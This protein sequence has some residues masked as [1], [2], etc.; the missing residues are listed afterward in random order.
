M[1]DVANLDAHSKGEQHAT[2]CSITR[3][4]SICRALGVVRV[5]VN[6]DGE[7]GREKLMFGGV[8]LSGLLVTLTET[9]DSSIET[10]DAGDDGWQASLSAGSAER[11][12]EKKNPRYC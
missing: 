4:G 8:E 1:G 9:A 3:C 6:F 10:H 12:S 7:A 2:P 11:A 5:S